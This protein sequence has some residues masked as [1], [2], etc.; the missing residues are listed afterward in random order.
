MNILIVEN[1]I[2]NAAAIKESIQSWD[3]DVEVS[4][5]GKEALE[6][7]TKKPFDLMLLDI[8]LPDCMGHEIIPKIKDIKHDIGIVTMTGF[9][10]RELELEVRQQGIFYY[11][12]KP[13]SLIML[14]EIIDHISKMKNEEEKVRDSICR[15]YRSNKRSPMGEGR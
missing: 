1:D 10:S 7:L 9:N 14:K 11:L 12:I 13:F 15:E 6:K 5:T 3:Y 8:Y 4:K 2:T